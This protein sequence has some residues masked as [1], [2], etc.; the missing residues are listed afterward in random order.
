V[1]YNED[2]MLDIVVGDRNGYVTFFRRTG[3][4]IHDLT[5][6]GHVGTTD[7]DIDVGTNSG[8]FI[9]DWN[10]DGLLDMIVGRE[11]TAGG[12]VWLY[13]NSGTVGNPVWTTYTAVNVGGSPIAYS[14]SIPHVIDLNLDGKKDMVIG[15]DYGHIYYLENTGT[16]ASP[17]FSSSVMLQANGTPIAFPSGYTDLKPYVVDWNNDGW[18]DIVTGNYVSYVYLYLSYPVSTGETAQPLEET[19]FAVAGSPFHGA[20][21]FMID[22]E[23]QC[24][25]EISIY[26]MD[27]RLV[28]TLDYGT[29]NAGQHMLH[30]ASDAYPAGAYA[31]VARLGDSVVTDRLVLLR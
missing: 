3:S 11:S 28:E 14:R 7:A 17:V 19:G 2:G 23:G 9:V 5:S 24:E 13:L 29:R 22:L 16:N 26:S 31:V 20:F 1:D 27:G 12:S 15:E 4:G 6:E 18:L 25:V 8:P 21:G 30:A 10:E